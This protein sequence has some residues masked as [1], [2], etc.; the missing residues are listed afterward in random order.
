MALALQ[1]AIWN[2]ERHEESSN[3]TKQPMSDVNANEDF[4]EVV[5]VAYIL[6]AVMHVL[7]G[8]EIS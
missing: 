1:Y 6:V 2:G 3:V 7:L 8:D 4:I 5:V